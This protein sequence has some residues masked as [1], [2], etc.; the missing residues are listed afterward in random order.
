MIV[1]WMER[2]IDLPVTQAEQQHR[3]RNMMNNFNDV[4]ELADIIAESRRN[5]EQWGDLAGF[6]G[7]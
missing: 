1:W 3:Y 5:R 7:S 6:P 4:E 2:E